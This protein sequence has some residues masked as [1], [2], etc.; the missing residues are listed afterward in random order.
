MLNCFRNY[1][2]NFYQWEVQS[3]PLKCQ[4]KKQQRLKGTTSMVVLNHYSFLQL[5]TSCHVFIVRGFCYW[6]ILRIVLY[7]TSQKFIW[8]KRKENKKYELRDEISVKSFGSRVIWIHKMNVIK[9][10]FDVMNKYLLELVTTSYKLT[11]CLNK[12]T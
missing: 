4:M 7:Y 1:E 9:E 6:L 8:K 5:P 3:N 11:I 2:L 10:I 12:K